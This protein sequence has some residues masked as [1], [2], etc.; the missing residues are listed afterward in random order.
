[1]KLLITGGCGFIGSN[2]IR[3]ILNKYPNYQIMNLDKLSYAG[4]PE[5]LKDVENNKNYNFV[6]GDICD[7]KIVSELVSEIDI[8]I[9]FAAESH[10]DRSIS[11]ADPFLNTN[12][13]GTHTLLKA[14]LKFKKR[15]L[16]ISTDE[17]YGSIEEGS[18]KENSILNPSSPYSASKASA[19]LLCISYFVTHK[20]R[21]TIVRSSNNFGPYQYPEKII[22]LF[23]TNI[24]ENKEVQLYGDGKNIRDWLFVMDNC[25]AIDLVLHK[26]NSGEIYNIASGK[27]LQNIELSNFLLKI[28]NKDSSSIEYIEDR[29]GHDRRYSLDIKKIRDLGWSPKYSFEEALKLTVN[30][31][32]NNGSWWKK[33]K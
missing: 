6:K 2:F 15:F 11:D 27:E 3:M 17:V 8:I 13:F 16:Q 30:W 26:G 22:P 25:E 19:D 24:L 5:N 18:F 7:T 29:K 12:I 21:V 1:M 33:L 28:F 31:Y 32:K 4:N 14:A 23:V 9:N 10:V 20:L